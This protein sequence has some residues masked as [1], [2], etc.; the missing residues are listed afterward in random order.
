[1]EVPERLDWRGEVVR[2]LDEEAVR[3]LAQRLRGEV[4]SVAVVL[5]F[6]FL[7]PAHERRVREILEEEGVDAPITLSSETLPELREYEQTSTTVLTAA[8]RP[9][10]GK[11]LE[12]LAE[13]LHE[14]G[15][16]AP[17]LLMQSN[18]GVA[19]VEE[20]S[21]R[22]AALLLSG[23][24]GGVEGARFVGVAAGFS[25]LIT[26]DMGGTSADVALIR[27]GEPTLTPEREIAGRPVRLP[28][29]DVHTVGAGGGSIAWV[30]EGGVL[31]VGPRSAGDVPGPACYGRGGTEP[32]VTDAHLLLGR[33]P[34][35]RPLG[36]LPTL[37]V[38]RAREAIRKIAEPLGF[39]PEEAAWGTLEVVE[40]TMERAIRV[41]TVERG[42]DPRD[43]TLVAFGG[44]GPLHGASLA[45]KLEIPR[46]LVPAQ[47]GVLSALGL[48]AADLRHTF[49][50]SLV[51]PLAE[52]TPE[53]VNG[54]LAA[55]RTKAHQLLANERVAEADMEFLPAA[56][57]RYRG[58]AYELSVPLPDRPLA[59]E[60]LQ[61]LAEA[62]H[63][64][65]EALYGYAVPDEPVELVS[66][67]LTATGRTPKPELLRAPKG[68]SL[69]EARIGVRPVYFGPDAGW[70]ETQILA[71]ERLP[72]GA[73]FP[74]PAVVEGA[75]S[76]VVVPPGTQARVDPF[77][78]LILEVGPWTP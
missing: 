4:E 11:Y 69:E 19:G 16:R 31:R 21:L 14:R 38:A 52:A 8:L 53:R 73:S 33:L 39:S 75:E 18:G 28:M 17:L 41:I 59:G 6:S 46:V 55:F 42:H 43:F 15:I 47:A 30:D 71:R 26:L 57:L 78:N 66:L 58:Q 77:G 48:L 62:F 5:L 68:G 44:A 23:P 37:S 3:R 32:T 34:P 7:N 74:G 61:R 65:H 2:P 20:A 12:R 13:A 49:V 60:D 25:D 70:I 10:V 56:D 63:Q 40:A 45:R 50:R 24:A 9:V 67:R 22:A 54:V 64:R 51:L 29:V 36:G 76:T 1:L 27:G 72:A 35:D